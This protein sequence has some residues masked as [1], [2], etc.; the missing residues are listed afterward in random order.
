MRSRARYFFANNAHARSGVEALVTNLVGTGITPASTA[1]NPEARAAL[2]ALWATWQNVADADGR[3]D[4]AG[5]LA[6]IVRAMILDGD[7]ILHL[8]E[9]TRGL[10]VR[11]LPAE[12]LD[13]A[14]TLD[15]GDGRYIVAGVEFAAD[16]T[17][18]AYWILPAKPTD[19]VT[20]APSIRIPAA[21]IL[22]LSAPVGIGQVRGV[23]WLAPV[24]LRLAEID[25]LDDAL[26]TGFKVAA[27]HAGFLIDQNGEAGLPY[28][29]DQQGSIL[30][31]GL[32]PGTL[33]RLPPGMDIR[34]N[35]P[36]QAQQ[37]TEYLQAQL[38]AVAAGLGVPE[39]MLTGD[40]SRANYSSL[41]AA[42]ITF[43]ARI[44]SLQYTILIPQIMRPLWER[45]VMSAILS[46]R[47]T[48][49]DF[50]SNMADYLS[51]EFYPPAIP[52]VD[53]VKDVQATKEAIAAGLMSRR[54]AVSALGFNIEDLDSEIAADRER[55]AALGLTFGQPPNAPESDNDD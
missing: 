9:T 28:D 10:R 14:K 36:A 20:Y 1:A 53:P 31:S 38:R 24:L 34:F 13:E 18:A 4:L 8:I 48:A 41:R 35:A 50:E 26:L 12:Q 16:G 52:F 46:G 39:H 3:T 2:A 49:S 25:G 40:V 5:V 30:T 45:F 37:S 42:L 21:D 15:L 27:L 22:H 7:A 44:E 19:V 55:E 51:A 32:E 54:Q 33:K 11:A 6:S 29:G 23:S 43:R 47:V 17:R